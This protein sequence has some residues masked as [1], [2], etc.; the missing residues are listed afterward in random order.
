MAIAT[1]A[2]DIEKQ[3]ADIK[4]S[5]ESA[6]SAESLAK[7]QSLQEELT[8]ANSLTTQQE[9]SYALQL[10]NR[11]ETQIILATMQEKVMAIDNEIYRQQEQATQKQKQIKDEEVVY[12]KLVQTKIAL[13][14]QYFT[15][16][17]QHIEGM[18][19]QITETIKLLQQM[20]ALS[21]GN[22]IAIK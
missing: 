15:L 6:T 17:N 18:K 13:D 3:I 20:S 5:G 21:G 7:L 11:T 22:T 10:A 12:K 19:T 9:K 2:I 4:A 16:F 1:R 8:F 14:N